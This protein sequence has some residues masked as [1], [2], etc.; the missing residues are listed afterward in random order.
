MIFFCLAH[1]N[2]IIV[3]YKSKFSLYCA[4]VIVTKDTVA[5]SGFQKRYSTTALELKDMTTGTPIDSFISSPIEDCIKLWL[6]TT[7]WCSDVPLSPTEQSV[8][9]VRTL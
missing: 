2:V 4:N 1:A 3:F 8:T 9:T 7:R 5:D 6:Q